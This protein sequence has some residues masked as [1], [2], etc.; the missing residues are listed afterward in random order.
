MGA[1]IK[2]N[3]VEF[4]FKQDPE[5]DWIVLKNTDKPSIILPID[6]IRSHNFSKVHIIISTNISVSTLY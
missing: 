5:S 4:N 6:T 3:E 2:S 1:S